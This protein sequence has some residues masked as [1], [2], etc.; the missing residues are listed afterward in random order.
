MGCDDFPRQ[1]AV[2]EQYFNPRIPYG[3]RL[4]TH[5]QDLIADSISI[6]ASRMG[7]DH[8]FYKSANTP[9]EIS[10]HASRMGCDLRRRYRHR[11]QVDFNPRIP[12]GMRQDSAL[13]YNPTRDFNPRIPYGM[14]RR[15]LVVCRHPQ[16]ISI[17]ASRMGCDSGNFKVTFRPRISIHASRMG[18]D[19]L[20]VEPY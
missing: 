17:H 15:G 6:H 1:S 13:T 11:A 18:C 2:L 10:I 20:H 7:C 16:K 4:D 19:A 14:R 9:K 12:Y 8:F 5:A 3:I